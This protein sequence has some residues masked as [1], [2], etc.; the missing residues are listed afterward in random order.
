MFEKGNTVTVTTKEGLFS[1]RTVAEV[2]PN[3]SLRMEPVTFLK[4][5]LQPAETFP[6]S[7]VWKCKEGC[8]CGDCV[9]KRKFTVVLPTSTK[10]G[11]SGEDTA[12]KRRG[13]P[14]GSKNQERDMSTVTVS[15]TD[16]VTAI[17]EQE[18]DLEPA[19]IVETTSA[20]KRRGRP[21]GSKNKPK[22]EAEIESDVKLIKPEPD[23]VAQVP[24]QV[25]IRT[26][27]VL[28]FSF[29]PTVRPET[30]TR[31]DTL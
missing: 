4:Y 8:G 28:I 6:L 16:V 26:E 1:C 10:T 18:P 23:T 31:R 13:R 11:G 7:A 2:L 5:I 15:A 24:A 14:P 27:P 20:P 21:P 12:P 19:E 25:Q 30:K 17:P 22:A 29:K 3:G 9:A